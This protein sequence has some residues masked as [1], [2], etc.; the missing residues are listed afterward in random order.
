MAGG[1]QWVWMCVYE[2]AK[3]EMQDAFLWILR[4]G[5]IRCSQPHTLAEYEE[6][7]NWVACCADFGILPHPEGGKGWP[8]SI[9]L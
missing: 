3:Q 5:M 4:D 7:I 6:N 9:W 1:A 8:R 2:L